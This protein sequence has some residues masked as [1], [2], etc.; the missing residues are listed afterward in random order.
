MSVFKRSGTAPLNQASTASAPKVYRRQATVPASPASLTAGTTGQVIAPLPPDAQN[1]LAPATLQDGTPTAS[2]AGQAALKPPERRPRW[3]SMSEG[4]DANEFIPPMSSQGQPAVMAVTL[5]ERRPRWAS[6]SEDDDLTAYTFPKAA[7]TPPPTV[8]EA[9]FESKPDPKPTWP[10]SQSESEDDVEGGSGKQFTRRY[11]WSEYPTT[12]LFLETA[13]NKPN[14]PGTEPRIGI[15]I[16]GVLTRE[17]DPR[18]R[19]SYDEWDASWEADGAL[20]AVKKITQVFGP[21]NTFLVSK[22]RPGG[23]MH[24]RM[25]LWLHETINFCEVTGLPKENIIFVRTVDGPTGKGVA[26]QKLGISHFVDDK[27][28]V[29]Q[30]VF[31]D[32][33]GNSRILVERHQGLLFH[34]SKGGYSQ[35]PPTTDTS[36][37]S[38]IMRRHYRSAAN[39]TQ[40]L[41]QLREKLPGQLYSRR[42]LLTPPIIRQ[43]QPGPSRVETRPPGPWEK[44]AMQ[45]TTN[46]APALQWSE[47]RPKLVLKPR[48]AQAAVP[49]SKVPAAAQ[50]PVSKAPA[51]TQPKPEAKPQPAPKAQPDVSAATIAPRPQPI[52]TDGPPTPPTWTQVVTQGPVTMRPRANTAPGSPTAIT[53]APR[54]CNGPCH[55]QVNGQ[56]IQQVPTMGAQQRACSPPSAVVVTGI[57][58][59][60]SAVQAGAV[61]PSGR[62][63]LQLKP[64]DPRLGPPGRSQ[65][66]V[67]PTAAEQP[68]AEPQPVQPQQ[69]QQPQPAQPAL[70]PDP[71]G[72][73]PRLVLKKRTDPAPVPSAAPTVASA[74]AVR[75]SSPPRVVPKAAQTSPVMRPAAAPAKQAPPNPVPV[76]VQLP[77]AGSC[78]KA[79]PALQKDPAG[80]RPRLVL[81]PRTSVS[82]TS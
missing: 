66:T 5:P 63:K 64:R 12:P 62:P 51:A 56:V 10:G 7:L 19:G 11:S 54:P 71:A 70:Q 81:K 22:V 18:Y 8:P 76:D 3:A 50:V 6:I 30:S 38:P 60:Q 59:V 39:W 47:G 42:D 61:S 72:G 79:A 68:P 55:G 37:L 28:E 13:A 2:P 77:S 45:S 48:S 26:C 34:F 25:E 41:E 82:S 57:G 27:I 44:G 20:D 1:R 49:V 75:V 35:V 52:S 65:A 21:S 16:G 14:A 32:E 23:R 33:A 17:G 40:V 36:Q 80:G 4:P 78:P 74:S 58:S 67:A 24:R 9:T 43:H 15:D 53:M 69:P 46:P 73:R 31:D 29:L